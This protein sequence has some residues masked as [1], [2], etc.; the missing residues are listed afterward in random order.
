MCSHA[1]DYGSGTCYAKPAAGGKCEDGL[2]PTRNVCSSDCTACG[3][4]LDSSAPSSSPA[5]TAEVW[6]PR[7]ELTHTSAVGATILKVVVRCMEPLG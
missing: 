4:Y 2:G 7:V 5:P 3:T 1:G 6:G